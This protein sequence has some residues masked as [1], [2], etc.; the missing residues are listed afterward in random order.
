[1][2]TLVDEILHTAD[3]RGE[4]GRGRGG[5][6]GYFRRL[7]IKKPFEFARYLCY[8]V[9]L[10]SG[11]S[12]K[13]PVEVACRT[14]DE[15]RSACET[16]WEVGRYPTHCKDEKLPAFVEEVWSWTPK[17]RDLFFNEWKVSPQQTPRDLPEIIIL[18]AHQLGE[19]GAGH[20]GFA[21]YLARLSIKCPAGY[22]QLLRLAARLKRHIDQPTQVRYETVDEIE[23]EMQRLGIPLS[24]VLVSCYDLHYH[25]PPPLID[26]DGVKRPARRWSRD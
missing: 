15:V 10:S 19:D 6:V 22:N 16:L 1:M 11:M 14:L 12:I 18:A 5:A 26:V 17:Q 13:E 7:A 2:R 23:E 9:P 21:G 8:A 25:E 20:K 24:K 3:R 4:D